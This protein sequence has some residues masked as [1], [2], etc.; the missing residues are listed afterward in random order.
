MSYAGHAQHYWWIS[1]P[2]SAQNARRVA[3]GVFDPK[4]EYLAE[5]L[6]RTSSKGHNARELESVVGW[7]LWMLGFSVIQLGAA[8]KMQDAAD[9]I[10]TVPSGHIAVIE[11]TTGT[12]KAEHKLALLHDR[13]QEVRRGL[14]AS[15]ARHVRVLTVMVTSQ[16]KADVEVD[17]EPAEKLGILVMTREDLEAGLQR[18][19]VNHDPDKIFEGA[20]AR[21][22]AAKAKYEA[23]SSLQFEAQP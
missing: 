11:V 3:Y 6:S 21:V 2:S 7:L 8:P 12:L 16:P 13:A 9:L 23:Q 18:T 4:L 17:L 1:D 19:T 14:E 15:G 20:E 10:A 22:K 5:V